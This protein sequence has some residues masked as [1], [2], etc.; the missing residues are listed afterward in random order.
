MSDI[1]YT[2]FLEAPLHQDQVKRNVNLMASYYE[3]SMEGKNCPL[4][5]IK[6]IVNNLS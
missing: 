3:V 4:N 2:F 1:T 5:E 6:M